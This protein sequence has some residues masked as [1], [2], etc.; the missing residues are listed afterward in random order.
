[1][2]FSHRGRSEGHTISID[3]RVP[4]F[5]AMRGTVQTIVQPTRLTTDERGTIQRAAAISRQTMS[6]LM[7]AAS[8]EYAQRLLV[9]GTA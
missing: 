8:M 9:K 3:R 6:E 4:F 2:I 5:I 7:R 1:L